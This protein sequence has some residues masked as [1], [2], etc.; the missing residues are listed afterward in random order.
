M[1][2]FQAFPTLLTNGKSSNNVYVANGYLP[3]KVACFSENLHSRP[4]TTPVTYYVF[5]TI[6]HHCNFT[7]IPHLTF[8]TT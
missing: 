7:G 5:S 3:Y 2:K 1:Q 4:L 8:F 6:P